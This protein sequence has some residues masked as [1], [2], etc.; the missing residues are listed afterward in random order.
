MEDSSSGRTWPE[1]ESAA[2]KVRAKWAEKQLIAS[3]IP[4]VRTSE[5]ITTRPHPIEIYNYKMKELLAAARQA[6]DL[7]SWIN[8]AVAKRLRTAIESM[9]ENQSPW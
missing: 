6:G 5:E 4:F 9:E 7:A 3:G 8:P 2:W 1:V